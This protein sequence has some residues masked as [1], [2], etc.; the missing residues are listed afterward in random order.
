LTLAQ[1]TTVVL[2]ASGTKHERE[3]AID[4]PVHDLGRRRAQPDPA[5]AHQPV[6]PSSSDE[7]MLTRRLANGLNVVLIPSSSV[8][9]VD[10]RLVFASGTAD[11]PPSTRGAA[12]LA[13]DALTW[14]LRYINDLLAFAGAGGTDR[15]TV[16]ADSTT[17]EAR[18]LDMHVDYLL[19]GL[20]R[21]VLEGTYTASSIALALRAQAKRAH[22]D[23]PIDAA[24]R[25]ALFGKGH[26]YDVAGDDVAAENG[27]T[28]DDAERF[29]ASHFTP[30]NATIVIAGRFD[31]ALAN[32]WI[33][34]LFSEWHGTA[35]VSS[36]RRG[37]PQPV[38]LAEATASEQLSMWISLPAN[39]GTTATQLVAAA[40]IDDIAGDVRHQ[41]GAAYAFGCE[42]RESRL[43]SRYAIEGGQVE[44]ARA[45]EVVD[46]VANRLSALRSDPDAAARS[47][48]VARGHVLVQ[49]A[50]PHGIASAIAANIEHDVA[51]RR[52]ATADSALVHEIEALTIDG[53]AAT[54]ADLDLARAAIAIRGPRDRIDEAYA[55][56]HRT[57]QYLEPGKTRPAIEYPPLVTAPPDIR[58]DE[59]ADSLTG[60]NSSRHVPRIAIGMS[61][62]YLT[63]SVDSHSADGWG[64][65]GEVGYNFDARAAVGLH[66]GLGSTSGSYSDGVLTLPV[67]FTLMPLDIKAYATGAYDRIW[68]KAMVG[69]HS[70]RLAAPGSI[71]W[72]SGTGLDLHVGVDLFDVYGYRI[73]PFVAAQGVLAGPTDS[74]AFVFGAIARR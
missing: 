17:F 74:T 23:S 64:V 42:L 60:G 29:R 53:M 41:L 19:A 31:P 70:D 21:R 49:L 34:Y 62:S 20:R 1:A 55:A 65:A 28:K 69:L 45:K 68:A 33:D 51:M 12:A 71:R 26:P 32:Q 15:V 10:I 18:G 30:D 22:R 63:T 3:L 35:H 2:K 44:A 14:D 57:P 59:I 8:P 47:F 50:A 7:P 24:Y 37:S 56:L 73:A 67:A 58:L 5:A 6:P 16:K 36:G 39:A 66:L 4:T 25:A 43:A 38:S 40:M 72:F 27:V 48:V 9:T 46:L 52:P 11:D 13:A 54:L 61:A